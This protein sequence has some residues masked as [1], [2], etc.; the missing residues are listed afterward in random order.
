MEEIRAVI[1]GTLHQFKKHAGDEVEKGEVL[2]EIESMKMLIPVEAPNTGKI[3]EWSV[4]EGE[5][6]NEND[7][8]GMLD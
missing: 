4:T 8:I 6:V 5:F 7:T 1:T 2:A 3:V